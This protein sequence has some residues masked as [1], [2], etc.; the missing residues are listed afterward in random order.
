MN[1]SIEEYQEL[2]AE[3]RHYLSDTY[4]LRRFGFL[5]TL[6]VLGYGFE[7]AN[8]HLLFL[9]SGVMVLFIWHERIR[10]LRNI[11]RVATYIEVI[12][13][14]HQRDLHWESLSSEHEFDLSSASKF[15]RMYADLD[16]PALYITNVSI[17][18]FKLWSESHLVSII[19]LVTLSVLFA[20][21]LKATIT[22]IRTG[23]EQ[24]RD[25]WKRVIRSNSTLEAE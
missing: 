23:K 4:R 21:E 9:I 2:R 5:I 6:G 3:I 1:S 7:A 11:F 16:L 13:E 14:P 10:T 20:A 22:V 17:G 18:I 12:I 25:K 8:T 19:V 24:E 15:S